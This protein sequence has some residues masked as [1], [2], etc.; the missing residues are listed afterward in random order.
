M[1]ERS[2]LD[3]SAS[4]GF[5]ARQ[6]EDTGRGDFQFSDPAAYS[7]SEGMRQFRGGGSG[8]GAILGKVFASSDPSARVFEALL[9]ASEIKL[10]WLCSSSY[11]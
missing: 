1:E 5:I 7:C 10:Y 3:K 6:I 9:I 2:T 4:R 11:V 8:S